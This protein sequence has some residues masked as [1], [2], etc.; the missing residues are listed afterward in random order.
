MIKY[1]RVVHQSSVIINSCT[2]SLRR[3]DNKV[4]LD[5]SLNNTIMPMYHNCTVSC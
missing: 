2:G 1:K 3:S 5:H 4:W